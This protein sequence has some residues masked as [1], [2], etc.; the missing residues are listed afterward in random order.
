[1]FL[2]PLGIL[3]GLA[4]DFDDFKLLSLVPPLVILV[5]VYLR[6][7]FLVR[8]LPKSKVKLKYKEATGKAVQ[9]L[10]T[11]NFYSMYVLST[12]LIIMSIF[13][14]QIFNMQY[15]EVMD[16][17]LMLLGMGIVSLLLGLFLHRL[18]KSYNAVK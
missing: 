13:T 10:P 2:L 12:S 17:T 1:M 8:N 18:K 5:I 9:G 6:Q 3:Y 11:W 14:P 15:S 4:L 7:Y 16:L